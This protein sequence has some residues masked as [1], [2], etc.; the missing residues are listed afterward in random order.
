MAALT[1]LA[2]PDDRKTEE[3]DKIIP[4]IKNDIRQMAEI[5]EKMNHPGQRSANSAAA[6]L[7][8]L[9]TICWENIR[10][11]SIFILILLTKTAKRIVSADSGICMKYLKISRNKI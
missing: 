2:F 5:M 9:K 3:A 4:H 10:E 6:L 11:T 8:I 1:L 7:T